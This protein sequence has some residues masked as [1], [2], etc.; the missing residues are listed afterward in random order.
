MCLV[1]TQQP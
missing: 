1:Y